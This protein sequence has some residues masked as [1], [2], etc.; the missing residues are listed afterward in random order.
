MGQNRNLGKVQNRI[1]FMLRQG[2]HPSPTIQRAFKAHG[3][4]SFAFEELERMEDE[5]LAYVLD[6]QLKQRVQ[7]WCT[8]VNAQPIL[9]WRRPDRRVC[10]LCPSLG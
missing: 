2:S 3:V 4:E 1:W 6:A 8:K 9:W 7:H 10:G 5:E